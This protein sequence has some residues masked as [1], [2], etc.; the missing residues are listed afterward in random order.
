M[1]TIS[2]GNARYHTPLIFFL[3]ACICLLPLP[4]AADKHA[5]NEPLFTL[6]ENVWATFYDLPSRRFRSIRDA[7][8]RRDFEAA[9]R[10]LEVT[11][12]FLSI[13]RGRTVAALRGPLTENMGQL[14]R[15]RANVR[16]QSVSTG[17]LDAAFARAHWLL[18]QHYLVLAMRARD[19][20]QHGNAGRYLWGTAHHLE[21]A[22]LWSDA[23]VDQAI[24]KSLDSTRDMG[25]R[26]QSSKNPQRVYRDK[27]I[28]VTAKTLIKIGEH[29]DRKVWVSES[30]KQ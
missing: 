5:D 26:L 18:A 20:G 21:R 30:L 19:S 29:L 28:A 24:V 8:I 4:S 22:V 14:E 11:I 1:R 27:P 15:I 23:R 9:E 10:D 16:D 17:D 6:D 25:T 3:G 13:E 2:K 7:F 12:G